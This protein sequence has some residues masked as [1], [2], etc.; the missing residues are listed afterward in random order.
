MKLENVLHVATEI[1]AAGASPPEVLSDCESKCFLSRVESFE[2]ILIQ[3][4]I[5]FIINIYVGLSVCRVSTWVSVSAC[6][7]K[8]VSMHG[9]VSQ[10]CNASGSRI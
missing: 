4:R 2:T 10:K 3:A 6:E 8:N 7:F 1:E 9:P 5:T